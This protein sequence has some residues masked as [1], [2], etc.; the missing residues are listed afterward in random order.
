MG[1]LNDAEIDNTDLPYL[2]IAIQNAS[3]AKKLMRERKYAEAAFYAEK[4]YKSIDE[5]Y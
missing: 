1:F 3:Q 2:E 5:L 4:G